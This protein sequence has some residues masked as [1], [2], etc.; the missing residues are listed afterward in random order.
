MAYSYTP[1]LK[2]SPR[3]R[4]VKER[5]LPI[6]GEVVVR[7]GDRV[8]SS[9][10]VARTKLPGAVHPVNCCSQLG[11]PPEDIER[12]LVVKPGEQVK[13]GE[14]I[15]VASSFFG[16]FKSRCESPV[17]G[18]LESASPV[19]GQ[20][21][22]REPPIPVEITA[23]IDG[24]VSQVYPQEGVEVETVGVFVQGIFGIGGERFGTVRFISPSPDHLV[25][26][27]GIPSDCEGQILVGGRRIT[28]E[29]FQK[30]IERGAVA[31]VVGGF[32]YRDLREILGYELGVA[33]TGHEEIPTT[34]ILTEGFGEIEMAHRTF[35]LLK[36]CEGQ[37]ASV[38][39]ATQIRAGVIRP[40]VIIPQEVETEVTVEVFSTGILE[41]GDTIR[42][43]R[44]PYFGAIGK[45]VAL[46]PMLQELETGAKV[47]VLVAD[48]G[49][50]QVVTLPRANVEII[51]E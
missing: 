26:E 18:V 15:A 8:K 46:P 49:N 13:K 3:A 51:E 2:V 31:V 10:V 35:A 9:Q 29:A 5:R 50:G 1:G 48:L 14:V 28:R 17:D 30:A 44:Q 33:I 40:E 20:V 24:K 16:I 11:I 19:T 47:R 32:H 41:V 12:A 42:V 27:S 23:Y 4:V 22:L 6:K 34:L 36:G 38:S 37:Q 7:E 43:I 25:D 21:M 45:V 39:G